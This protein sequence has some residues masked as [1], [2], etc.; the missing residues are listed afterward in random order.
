MKVENTST[1]KEIYG[2]ISNIFILEDTDN[3]LYELKEN[4]DK[5]HFSKNR[6]VLLEVVNDNVLIDKETKAE[7]KNENINNNDDSSEKKMCNKIDMD[8]DFDYDINELFFTNS[9]DYEYDFSGIGNDIL[10]DFHSNPNIKENIFW[11]Y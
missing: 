4:K 1:I 8:L 5:R 7:N 6:K 9:H 11:F 3:I 10:F 2:T